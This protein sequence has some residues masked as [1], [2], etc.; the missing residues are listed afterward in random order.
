M[1]PTQMAVRDPFGRPFLNFRISVTQRC[2]F[3]CPYCHREGQEAAYTEMTA[4]EITRLTRVAV[5]LGARS[6]KITG[7]EPLMRGDVYPII[8]CIASLP[9]VE[10]LSMTTNGSLLPGKACALRNCGLDRLN[11]NLLTVDPYRYRKLMGGDLESVLQGIDEAAAC[12][13]H[14]IKLNMLVMRG[15]NDDH[16]QTM[17]DFAGNN[18]YTLQLIELEPV[19]LDG[20]FYEERHLPLNGIAEELR[21]KSVKIVVRRHTNNRRVYHLPGATVE[22]VPPIENTEFCANC[23][24]LRLTSDG[25][26]KPCLMRNDNLIDV[27]TPLRE[28]ADDSELTELFLRA[29]SLREPYNKPAYKANPTI[30]AV[31]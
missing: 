1:K 26:L 29:I 17:I 24:R 2:A 14:P 22:V 15:V 27:L 4:A 11:V 19:N 7:G 3:H 28:G 16:V 31:R 23:A 12:G 8:R 30:E 13:L 6:V 5:G 20:D 9:H 25:K 18:G 21:R 10:D